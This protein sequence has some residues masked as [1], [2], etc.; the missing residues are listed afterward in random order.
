VWQNSDAGLTVLSQ[1]IA[2]RAGSGF[3][4]NDRLEAVDAARGRIGGY[5]VF[6]QALEVGGEL[7]R[8]EAP[9]G[10]GACLGAEGA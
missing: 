6:L 3:V 9:F 8:Q 10:V 4:A 5:Q 7:G 1:G 2:Y